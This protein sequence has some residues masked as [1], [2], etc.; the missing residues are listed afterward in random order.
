MNCG[1][2]V[3]RWRDRQGKATLTYLAPSMIEA[4][5]AEARRKN[6]AVWKLTA[7]AF[8]TAFPRHSDGAGSRE[9]PLY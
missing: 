3:K 8:H 1:F 2:R 9:K 7:V 5:K 6:K 4:L